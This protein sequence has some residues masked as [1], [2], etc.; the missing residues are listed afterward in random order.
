MIVVEKMETTNDNT[1]VTYIHSIAYPEDGLYNTGV[2]RGTIT[3]RKKQPILEAVW[4]EKLLF[5]AVKSAQDV[6]V[7]RLR[8]F[9]S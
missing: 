9:V 2:R 7:R 6:S 4:S 3:F 8:A 5:D 1:V